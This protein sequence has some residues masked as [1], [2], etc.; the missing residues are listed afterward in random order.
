LN[1]ELSARTE[2]GGDEQHRTHLPR[3]AAVPGQRRELRSPRKN[4][5][6]RAFDLETANA[7]AEPVARV[8]V[9]PTHSVARRR[10]RV[11]EHVNI[12]V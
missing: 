9:V 3:A 2:V 5:D 7:D 11:G 10:R 4:P 6:A 8:E 1:R 12:V